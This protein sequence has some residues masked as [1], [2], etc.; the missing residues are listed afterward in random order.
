MHYASDA[1]SAD[2][3]P[4]AWAGH[5]DPD[6]TETI[7]VWDCA[8]DCPVRLLDEQ[9]G[10]NVDGARI[11]TCKQ[12]LGSMPAKG[13]AAAK[14][15]GRGHSI[16]PVG[17]GQDR[18]V[19]RWPANLALSHTPEC[20]PVGTKIEE[21]YTINRWSD[22]AKPFGGGAG[23]PYEGEQTPDKE[24]LV[25]DCA[26]DC[27]VRMLDEQSEETGAQAPVRDTEPSRAAEPGTVTGRQERVKGGASRFFFNAVPDEVLRF[28]YCAKASKKE[29]NA[30]LDTFEAKTVS[31]GREVVN[32][33]A[34]P[35]DASLRK[36]T[37]P[38]VK[39][40]DFCRWVATLL[41]PPPRADGRP[42]RILVPFSGS[43][44]EMIGC[45]LAGWDE[46]VGIE[47]EEEYAAI[48]NARLLHWVNQMQGV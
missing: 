20:R 32:D 29:K 26:P 17:P 6:G 23:Q 5:A 1:R 9:S 15:M 7:E 42:R 37:H 33:T 48:A 11:G 43:G 4:G 8:P 44:S 31:D 3:R 41:L 27:P 22:G 21:G 39:P 38:C 28:K 10:I 35:R 45:L 2:V 13:V 30:G 34:Y 19:G 24:V 16:R 12:V 14:K 46:V 47:L 40:L 36:N 18:N 25:W